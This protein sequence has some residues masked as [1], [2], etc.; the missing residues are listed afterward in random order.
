MPAGW[1]RVGWFFA[2]TLLLLLLIPLIETALGGGGLDFEAAAARASAESGLAWTSS[3]WTVA[4]LCLVEPTL[5]LHRGR[6]RA[7]PRAHSKLRTSFPTVEP[8]A[9]ISCARAAS[10]S[11]KRPVTTG[12]ILPSE[13]RERSCSRS[14]RNQL[15]RRRFSIWML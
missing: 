7:P 9:R 10:W 12:R 3:L 2:L 15:G 14:S 11:G 6:L 4:R 1:Q 5:C 8:A 13:R